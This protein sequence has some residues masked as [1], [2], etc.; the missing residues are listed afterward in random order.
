MEKLL[1]SRKQ[2][3]IGVRSCR[4][5]YGKS[6]SITLSRKR[7]CLALMYKVHSWLGHFS[8]TFGGIAAICAADASLTEAECCYSQKISC[9][10]NEFD[11]SSSLLIKFLPAVDVGSSWLCHPMGA[12]YVN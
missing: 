4:D 9:I 3:L 12:F 11:I 6:A 2:A 7:V 5:Q 10:V 8:N 1:I